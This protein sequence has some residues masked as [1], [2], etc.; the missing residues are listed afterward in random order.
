MQIHVVAG[1]LVVDEIDLLITLRE[2]LLVCY[3]NT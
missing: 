3:E 1:I 2:E